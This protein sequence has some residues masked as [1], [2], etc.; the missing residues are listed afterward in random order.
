MIKL[1]NKAKNLEILQ[2]IF[3]GDANI[4]IPYFYFFS[5]K[6]FQSNK[7]YYLKKIT[8]FT[9]NCKIILR[10]SSIDED[11]INFSNAGKYDSIIIAK[12]TTL[13]R[14]KKI[15]DRFVKQFKNKKD[16]IIVQELIEKVQI[17]GVIFTNDI[18][19]NAPYYLINYDESGKTDLVTSGKKSLTHKQYIQF[20]NYSSGFNK[21]DKLISACKKL[22]HKFNYARLDIEFC[23]K[24]NQIYLLQVRFLPL[25]NNKRVKIKLD[26]PLIN[27]KKKIIKLFKINPT[28]SG[29]KTAFSNM[30]DW[31]PVEMI[32]EKPSKLA[33]SLYKELITDSIWRIQR[34]KYGYRDVFPN[35]L[36][37]ELGGSPFVDL[38]TDINSFLPNK[39]NK[40]SFRKNIKQIYRFYM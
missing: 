20:K 33:I 40:K 15:L 25:A 5:V 14:V 24:N 27:I 30:S 28:L 21:F 16:L 10:S 11:T 9:K 32:G 36:I 3:L 35:I 37:F 22:E 13:E 1:K 26:Q 23:I 6:K 31:N 18:N 39:L 2:K 8:N 19:S 4:K 17:S 29:K 12:S 34:K 7:K 38:R